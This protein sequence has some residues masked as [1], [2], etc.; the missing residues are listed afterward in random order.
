MTDHAHAQVHRIRQMTGRDP[1]EEGRVS[2][3]LE[4]L[5]DLTFVIAVGVAATYLAEVTA[6]GHILPALLGF[7][8]ATF[9]ITWAWINFTWFASAFDTDDWVY[10]AMT[11]VQMVGVVILALGIPAMFESIE[12][13]HHLDNRVIVAGYVVMRVAM[14]SQ[15]LRVAKQSPEYRDTALRYAKGVG[16][17]Q[18]GWVVVAIIELPLVPTLCLTTALTVFEMCVP[19]WAE[20][21]THPTP[22]HPHHIAERYSLFAII[23]LGEG[24]VGTI[25]SSTGVLGGEHGGQWTW[26]A[27]AVVIAGV[28]L[29][30]GLWWIY[31]INPFGKVLEQRPQL[32]WLFGYGHIIVF[33]SI[34]AV[35]AAL[36]LAGLYVEHHTQL[37][38]TQVIVF[39]AV[40]IAIYIVSIYAI[41]LVLLPVWSSLYAWLIVAAV[42]V[43]GLAIALAAAGVSV[44]VCL[45]I[46]MVAP[47]IQ[48]VGYES[49]GHNFQQQALDQLS[50]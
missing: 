7:G 47:F 37:S 41:H 36:H 8:F 29:T 22:W 46:V 24:L 3:P 28:G 9:A 27:V 43:L 42:V 18:I 11:M 20:A 38:A 25:A 5:F 23:A 44:P 34:V 33:G 40:P 32:A 48:V 14:I 1:H 45:L 2:S 10:R 35:G 50:D 4:L 26:D 19:F 13:G 39:I 21:T 49:R 31:F 16:L 6:E 15:W 12:E 30:F 17:A